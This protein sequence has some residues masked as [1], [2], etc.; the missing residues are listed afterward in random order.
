M[1]K[2][3]IFIAAA[4]VSVVF[5][6]LVCGESSGDLVNVT[7]LVGDYVA[8]NPGLETVIPH[9]SHIDS[10]HDGYIEGYT[11]S[12]DIYKTGT[13]TKLFSTPPKSITVCPGGSYSSGRDTTVKRLGNTLVGFS[14]GYGSCINSSYKPPSGH[15]YAINLSAAGKQPWVKTVNNTFDGNG[16]VSD[17]NGNGTGELLVTSANFDT[18]NQATYTFDRKVDIF[19]GDTGNTL[20]SKIYS[21]NTAFFNGTD[22]FSYVVGLANTSA[23]VGDYVIGNPGQETVMGVNSLSTGCNARFDVY[24]AGTS[25]KLFSTPE[26]T[27]SRCGV[28]LIRRIGNMLVGASVG[29]DSNGS[30]GDNS[31]ASFYAVDLSMAGKQPWV[32]SIN[33]PIEGMGIL[34][35]MNKNGIGEMLITTI[36]N[37]TDGT[38]DRA[39]NI[40]DGGTGGTLSSKTYTNI[41][42]I[43]AGY[44]SD[45]SGDALRNLSPLVGDY[46]ASNAGFETVIPH[47]G[48]IDSNN[49]GVAE[50]YTLRFDVYKTG[51]DTKLFST[52]E[53]PFTVCPSSMKAPL[54]NHFLK[55]IGNTLMVVTTVPTSVC[56]NSTYT[57]PSG[58]VYAVNLSATGKQPWT[59]SV[60]HKFTGLGILPDMNNNGVGELLV[61]PTDDSSTTHDYYIYIFDGDTG[62]TLSSKMYSKPR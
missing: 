14:S 21:D 42:N 48:V 43:L 40:Y 45:G 3:T 32:K 56:N 61:M 18:L 7:P 33:Q 50:G 26:K 25:T 31:G 41:S 10:N 11:L 47:S 12:L 51:T 9:D 4:A 15:I 22:Y 35:D 54:F 39:V 2:S 52:P 37:K 17:M 57:P 59:K 24:K 58:F 49:D 46:V 23:L 6:P 60:N 19:D 8:N 62:A 34:P 55:R 30:V 38:F 27:L 1:R 16:I 36:A 29:T 28:A 5:S 13:D 20:S 53:K 44:F